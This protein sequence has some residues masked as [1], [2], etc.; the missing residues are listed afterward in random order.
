MPRDAVNIRRNGP[1]APIVLDGEHFV[2]RLRDAKG[3]LLYVG[4]TN[5]LPRR[6]ATHEREKS[7]WSDVA[8]ID[9]STYPDR[10]EAL[11]A[12][13]AAVAQE[14]PRHNKALNPAWQRP[15]PPA[16][17]GICSSCRTEQRID[18]CGFVRNHNRS[19]R[20]CPGTGQRPAGGG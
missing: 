1:Y 7:W 18:T 6:L 15:A 20:W 2:Y 11:D 5:N 14:K 9:T 8:A 10:R 12:E 4:V 19:G 3:H 16:I 17:S 13:R